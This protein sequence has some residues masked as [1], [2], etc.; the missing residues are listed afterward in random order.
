MSNYYLYKSQKFE[1][2]GPTGSK[3]ISGVCYF[4]NNGPTWLVDGVVVDGVVVDVNPVCKKKKWRQRELFHNHHFATT[5]HGFRFTQIFRQTNVARRGTS[6][7]QGKKTCLWK[8][9]TLSFKKVKLKI[10]PNF[11]GHSRNIS[12]FVLYSKVRV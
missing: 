8:L 7:Y 4:E 3:T 9:W 2:F 11:F 1:F 6:G 10:L 12:V 5:I